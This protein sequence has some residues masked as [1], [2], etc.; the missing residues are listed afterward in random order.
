MNY[1]EMVGQL[2]ST[3]EEDS[4][5]VSPMVLLEL[6][7]CLQER[8]KKQPD[9]TLNS[10]ADSLN[11]HVVALA[12]H[13]WSVAK[14]FSGKGPIA[15][16]LRDYAAMSAHYSIG[17]YKLN[18]QL[19]K[20]DFQ[21]VDDAA[22][23]KAFRRWLEDVAINAFGVPHDIELPL[24][25]TPGLEVGL[26]T[27]IHTTAPSTYA[28][29]AVVP[30]YLVLAVDLANGMRVKY[31][32]LR[33]HRAT[34]LYWHPHEE[35][36][37]A[38]GGEVVF[39]GVQ[40]ALAVE[41][42]KL[43]NQCG[44]TGEAIDVEANMAQIHEKVYRIFDHE[45]RLP[46]TNHHYVR[47]E[48]GDSSYLRFVLEEYILLFMNTKGQWPSRNTILSI[49]GGSAFNSKI[50]F[51]Q[52]R[53]FARQELIKNV[54]KGLDDIIAQNLQDIEPPPGKMA[55]EKELAE[56]VT[57]PGIGEGE[58]PKP[59]IPNYNPVWKA[60]QGKEKK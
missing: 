9:T 4:S 21:P 56:T 3:I 2:K 51:S 53:E 27:G 20:F 45:E 33:H 17:S 47:T 24:P 36:W 50:E 28:P 10:I 23:G 60:M 59:E 49:N 54:H 18:E 30:R 52:M 19:K 14:Y 31:I 7:H 29:D 6:I 5:D 43:A 25:Y 46:Q 44:Y 38:D 12:Q 26:C 15:C 48:D 42:E 13:K 8:F 58:I 40:E 34:L 39:E 37:L 22:R 55:A 11:S 35:V 1:S 16:K 57:T 32:V 41:W